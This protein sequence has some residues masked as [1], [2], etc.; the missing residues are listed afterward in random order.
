[1]VT[2]VPKDF[3]AGELDADDPAAQD[4]GAVWHVVHLQRFL[5]GD[6]PPTDVQTR[7]RACVGPG[8]QHDGPVL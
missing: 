7:Q 6:D 3:H 2:S 1:M 4:D 8:G 5:T